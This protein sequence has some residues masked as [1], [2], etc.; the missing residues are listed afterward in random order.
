MGVANTVRLLLVLLVILQ[1][2]LDVLGER[3]G[4]EGGAADAIDLG[5]LG[6]GHCKALKCWSTALAR[7]K[8]LGVSLLGRASTLTTLFFSICINTGV[9]PLKPRTCAPNWVVLTMV[10]LPLR[11]MISSAGRALMS[12]ATTTA[13]ITEASIR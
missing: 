4:T 9:A 2:E 13:A 11:V 3:I 10:V 5:L 6:L 1:S 12:S 7:A 8:N